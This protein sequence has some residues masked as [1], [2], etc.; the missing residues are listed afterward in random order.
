MEAV[1]TTAELRFFAEDDILRCK[2][3]ISNGSLRYDSKNPNYFP[4]CDFSKLLVKFI[5]FKVL[6]NGVKDTLDELRTRFWISK[7]RK[8]ISSV[9]KS[10]FICK[11]VEVLAYK[12]PPAPDLP[13]TRV[14]VALVLIMLDL[15]L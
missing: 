15:Y 11:K 6:H 9:I 2:G 3:R 8:F 12:Y 5:H 1:Q 13:S 7:A 14:A 10:C 4:K